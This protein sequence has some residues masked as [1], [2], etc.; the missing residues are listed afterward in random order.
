MTTDATRKFT[1]VMTSA[2]EYLG[3]D[4]ND[5]KATLVNDTLKSLVVSDVANVSG[6]PESKVRQLLSGALDTPT[7]NPKKVN[8]RSGLRTPKSN[9]NKFSQSEFVKPFTEFVS[10]DAA[11]INL[12]TI[13]KAAMATMVDDVDVARMLGD[14]NYETKLKEVVADL[15]DV[16]SDVVD[17]V[18]KNGAS[19]AT[20]AEVDKVILDLVNNELEDAGARVL[21][22]ID[23][24]KV[25]NLDLTK[26]TLAPAS[27][28][29]V[30]YIGRVTPEATPYTY[31]LEENIPSVTRQLESD[32]FFNPKL[33]DT[34][35]DILQSLNDLNEPKNYTHTALQGEEV[36]PGL[37]DEPIDD[38]V[39]QGTTPLLQK[40]A[41]AEYAREGIFLKTSEAI[42][43]FTDNAPKDAK[44]FK[45]IIPPGN[46]R[47][48]GTVQS[49][50]VN[51]SK[52]P[53][54]KYKVTP[55]VDAV[56]TVIE[57]NQAFNKARKPKGKAYS[58]LE[59][60]DITT[61]KP[62]EY[63]A[64]NAPSGAKSYDY[65]IG[66]PSYNN[67]QQFTV[68]Y[69]DSTD[70][71][72]KLDPPA[73]NLITTASESPVPSTALIG[74]ADVDATLN[75]TLPELAKLEQKTEA[76]R[77]A[78]QLTPEINV[79][80]TGDNFTLNI[81]GREDLTVELSGDGLS[82]VIDG[83]PITDTVSTEN[84]SKL[85]ELQI[86][87][88]A[89]SYSEAK[90]LALVDNTVA[91]NVSQLEIEVPQVVKLTDPIVAPKRVAIPVDGRPIQ[92]IEH[93]TVLRSDGNSLTMVTSVLDDLGSIAVPSTQL[94]FPTKVGTLTSREI[95]A[96]PKAVLADLLPDLQKIQL[97]VID[98]LDVLDN[99]NYPSVGIVREGDTEYIDD[100]FKILSTPPA[101]PIPLPKLANKLGDVIVIDRKAGKVGF[102]GTSVRN[103]QPIRDVATESINS[104]GFGTY[105]TSDANYAKSAA[106]RFY[107]NDFSNTRIDLGKPSVHLVDA[108]API[109][110][111]DAGSKILPNS[112]K[113][114][115]Q[116]YITDLDLNALFKANNATSVKDIYSKIINFSVVDGVIDP[117]TSRSLLALMD[118]YLVEHGFKG[119]RD[120]VNNTI[121]LMNTEGLTTRLAY[122][123][124]FNPLDKHELLESSFNSLKISSRQTFD[125]ALDFS[126]AVDDK[127]E[128]LKQANAVLDDQIRKAT[129]IRVAIANGTDLTDDVY[130]GARASESGVNSSLADAEFMDDIENLGSK[131]DIDNPC[132]Y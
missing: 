87:N 16:P 66:A 48:K 56:G 28:P 13:L 59:V 40:L 61:F 132:D 117:V 81:R 109:K 53:K 11:G 122:Q 84:V 37:I 118:N 125:N 92:K 39:V 22:A 60:D 103:W 98:G 123:L 85:F 63:F 82:T 94:G 42:Q 111:I 116:Q 69:S 29:D 15:L 119:I 126:R 70:L 90:P 102:H 20:T 25:V 72:Y 32:S 80:P 108:E 104:L 34:T 112:V 130:Y 124:P 10:D 52:T 79:I 2:A 35:N 76:I 46:G 88:T 9:T 33:N 43:Y 110:L 99:A 97:Q 127:Y 129:Q 95:S 30:D 50:F 3:I 4:V 55:G 54:L 101:N 89:P 58:V 31:V 6:L 107:G 41:E 23:D 93:G 105:L 1:D 115:M 5:V 113:K 131:I 73:V 65:R 83:V 18:I 128:V 51:Y 27:K 24:S 64:A 75:V 17:N 12:A 21:G 78:L 86:N 57:T 91:D 45:V 49:Y 36:I 19:P 77:N 26:E 120:T 8:P 71:E 38:A 100:V 62:K 67:K 7:V 121:K 44:S 74:K 14:A 106:N 114:Y 96:L 68:Q 47:E